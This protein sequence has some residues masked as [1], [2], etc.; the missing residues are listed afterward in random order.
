M[1]AMWTRFLPHIAEVKRLIAAGTLGDIVTV[2]ADHGQWFPKDPSFRLFA[3]ELGGGVLLDCGVYPVS[4]ASMILGPPDQILALVTPTFTGVD[5]QT[6][7]LFGYQSGAQAVLTCTSSAKTPVRAAI[8]G[9]EARHRD[10]HRLLRAFVVHSY[11]SRRGIYPLRTGSHRQG[12]ALRGRRGGTLPKGRTSGESLDAA[13]REHR[14]Y[15]HYGHGPRPG[16][17]ERQAH[18]QPGNW[19]EAGILAG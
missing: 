8:V 13:R 9:T 11:P 19:S 17:A 6:S 5:G 12:S 15:G 3:H 18:K 16:V 4:F 2:I 7:M 1:E 10:R 14:D